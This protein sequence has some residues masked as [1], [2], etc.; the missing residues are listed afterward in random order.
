MDANRPTPRNGENVSGESYPQYC[1][2]CRSSW[3][4]LGSLDEGDR[5]SCPGCGEIE[6]PT[7]TFFQW[8]VTENHETSPTVE[9]TI[10]PEVSAAVDVLDRETSIERCD[11]LADII[12]P[13]WRVVEDE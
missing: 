2:Q 5:R 12:T 6:A 3:R 9:V 1:L 11:L 7:T 4:V 13:Q 10:P 8:W